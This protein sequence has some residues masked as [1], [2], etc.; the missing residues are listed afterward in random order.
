MGVAVAV[1]L[2]WTYFDV[3]ALVAERRLA[4]LSGLER[5]AMARDSYTY[6]H[7]PMVAGI[8]LLALGAKILLHAAT[9]DPSPGH[10]VESSPLAT[11]ALYGGTAAY[12]LAHIA[13]RWRNVHSVNRQRAV[14]S[15][16]L[17]ALAVWAYLGGAEVAPLLHLCV[18]AGVLAALVVYEVIRFA[19]ARRDVRH[20]TADA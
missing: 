7:L 1:C 11:A 9:A 4:G 15:C 16:V 14:T 5:T 18:L 19:G 6:L 3:V 8:V 10:P 17:V 20:A 2:W 12:L 13:F